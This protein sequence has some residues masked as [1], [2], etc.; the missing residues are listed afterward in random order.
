MDLSPSSKER[1]REEL[2]QIWD[3]LMAKES[4]KATELA[5][6]PADSKDPTSISE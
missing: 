4:A 6:L 3:Q 1:I 5:E 2:K